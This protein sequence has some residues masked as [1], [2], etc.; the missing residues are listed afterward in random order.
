M[1]L[2]ACLDDAAATPVAPEAADAMLPFLRAAIGKPSS[3]HAFGQRAGKAVRESRER[4]A[5]P[6]GR[7]PTDLVLAECAMRLPF[8]DGAFDATVSVA[9]LCFVTRWHD[10]LAEIVSAGRVSS[11]RD[12]RARVRHRASTARGRNEKGWAA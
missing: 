7:A 2:P 3:S 6:I 1:G 4:V 11:C 8:A 10:A 5:A 9:A 12:A